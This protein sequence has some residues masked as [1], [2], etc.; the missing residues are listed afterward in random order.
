MEMCL[1]T[2]GSSNTSSVTELHSAPGPGG[3]LGG[4]SPNCIHKADE[5]HWERVGPVL[6]GGLLCDKRARWWGST[7]SCSAWACNDQHNAGAKCLNEEH[8]FVS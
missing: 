7:A 4:N 1:G 5:D 2:S 8:V 3:M 6:L